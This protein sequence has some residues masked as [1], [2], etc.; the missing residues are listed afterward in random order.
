MRSDW[1]RAESPY[2]LKDQARS[3]DIR[4]KAVDVA[5]N[6]RIA[7]IPARY[8]A[9]EADLNAPLHRNTIMIV[10]TLLLVTLAVFVQQFLLRNDRRQDSQPENRT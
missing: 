3:S 8:E 5:G 10:V 2:V 4:V 9:Q 6:E 7:L 1:R